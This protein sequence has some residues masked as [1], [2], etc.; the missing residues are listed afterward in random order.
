MINQVADLPKG[1][2]Y[3]EFFY[4]YNR[5]HKNTFFCF[6]QRRDLETVEKE[7]FKDSQN[8]PFDLHICKII[9]SFIKF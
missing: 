9:Y 3:F 5:V 6:L 8:I 4:F 2:M 1:C 7:R